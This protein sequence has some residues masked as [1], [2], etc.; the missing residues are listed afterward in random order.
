M[1]EGG[2]AGRIAAR[3]SRI[4]GGTSGDVLALASGEPQLARVLEGGDV[5]AAE[6]AHAIRR[7]HARTLSDLMLRRMELGTAGRPEA[8]LANEVARVAASELGWNDA[9]REREVEALFSRYG[10]FTTSD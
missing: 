7:E 3:L 1:R 10:W 6:V 4:R 9:R 8:G 2:Q 5:L